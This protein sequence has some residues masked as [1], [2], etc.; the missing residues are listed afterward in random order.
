M[1]DAH[2]RRRLGRWRNAIIAG[3]GLGGITVS[4]WGTRLPDITA[5]L[6]VDT[7]TIGTVLAFVTVGSIGGLLAS[8]PVA[9]RFGTRRGVGAALLVIAAAMALLGVA[10]A[11]RGIPMMAV[12][13]AVVGFGI[14]L[15][16][17][18]LN[19]E[20]SAVEREAARTLM[21][22]M[23][24]AWSVGVAVGSGIGAACAALGVAPAQQF[25]GEAV[26]IAV[27]AVL[28]PRALPAHAAPVE[29]AEPKRPAEAVREWL[30]GWLDL[31]LLLIGVVLLGVEL[32]EGSANTWLTLG[33]QREHGQTAAVA[34]LFFTAF[35]VG[36][37]ITRILA[38]PVVDRMGRVAAIRITTAI[39]VAG[40]V[41]FVLGG[42]AGLVLLGVLLW[43]VGV[44]MG[45][46]LG[47]SAAAEGGGANPAARVSVVASIGYF[48][49]LAGPP[50]I[51][52]LAER[53]GLLQSFWLIVVLLLA[54]FAASG[55]VAKPRRPSAS[56]P[57]PERSTP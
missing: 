18:L 24:G 4:S 10:I 9:H 3:F 28:V 35:A 33:V 27:A 38:G 57:I 26:L 54:A 29:A 39:G 53:V 21:P 11:V 6:R 48:A 12:T 25:V 17:V 7:G 51:G 8:T 44:S 16:D 15:L 22:L 19:V 13:F 31:R 55:A 37:A 32:G 45:F 43:S 36:E 30:R 23:H 49:S 40:L 2:A 50:A 42:T 56:A 20:G 14:G 5:E 41:L 47:M 46:P 52:L 1:T 34:A